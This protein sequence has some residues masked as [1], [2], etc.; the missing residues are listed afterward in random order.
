MP[1]VTASLLTDAW[2]IWP[3]AVLNRE[4]WFEKSPGVLRS[5]DGWTLYERSSPEQQIINQM[6]TITAWAEQYFAEHH[7]FPTAQ[8]GEIKSAAYRNPFT[9]RTD[10]PSLQ[11]LQLKD[12]AAA[13]ALASSLYRGGHWD[14][15]PASYPGSIDCLSVTLKSDPSQRYFFIRGCDSKAHSLAGQQPGR[16]HA[17]VIQNGFMRPTESRMP[18]FLETSSARPKRLC[19]IEQSSVPLLLLRYGLTV[20]FAFITVLSAIPACLLK[21]TKNSLMRGV[22]DA[23]FTAFRLF[24]SLLIFS[25]ILYVL[26]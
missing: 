18:K 12:V 13:E 2:R 20:L 7:T 11:E 3:G 8:A 4:W 25:I 14:K 22:H 21:K 5:E 23:C 6:E 10:T 19:L 1:Y 16:A 17:I 26:T 15:E 9:T 24:L